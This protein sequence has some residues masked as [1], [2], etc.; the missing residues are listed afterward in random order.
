MRE[1]SLWRDGYWKQRWQNKLL[2]KKKI[3]T[4]LEHRLACWGKECPFLQGR[5]QAHEN[6]YHDSQVGGAERETW[7]HSFSMAYGCLWNRKQRSW[8]RDENESHDPETMLEVWDSPFEN[9][10]GSLPGIRQMKM[11]GQMTTIIYP[12]Y[13]FL[14]KNVNTLATLIKTTGWGVKNYF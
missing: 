9:V 12:S 8:L 2:V 10:K 11:K 6:G 14:S 13:N 3:R 4:S 1:S 5:L 7:R